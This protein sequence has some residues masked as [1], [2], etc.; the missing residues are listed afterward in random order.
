MRNSSGAGSFWANGSLS[1]FFTL[2]LARARDVSARPGRRV[3][4]PRSEL[5]SR[6]LRSDTAAMN[7]F[8]FFGDMTHLCSILVRVPTARSTFSRSLLADVRRTKR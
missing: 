4:H 8:R 6:R 2:L 5:A 7:I 3:D 1:S